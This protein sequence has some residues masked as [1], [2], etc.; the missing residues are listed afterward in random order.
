DAQV[1]ATIAGLT[2]LRRVEPRRGDGQRLVLEGGGIET[3]GDGLLLVTDEWLLTDVQV[4]NP[5]LG[6]GDY[7]AEFAKWLGTRHT[8]WLGEGVIGDDTHGHIDDIARFVSR[9]TIVVAVEADPADEHHERSMDNVRR[10]ELAAQ[11]PQVG[12]LR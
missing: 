1:G 6:R 4:R 8:I 2:G 10:L 11:Q 5:G 3:N 12:P 7:E 9:D